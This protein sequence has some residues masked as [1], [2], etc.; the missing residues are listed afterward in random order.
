MKKNKIIPKKF[1]PSRLPINSTVLYSFL[2][3]FFNAPQWLWGV[4]LTLLI[5]FW[6]IAIIAFMNQE[7]DIDLINYKDESK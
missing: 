7:E 5:I 6:I 1:F 4:Y 2:M 3:Y